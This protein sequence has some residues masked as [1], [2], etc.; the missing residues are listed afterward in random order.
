MVPKARI[1]YVPS[2]SVMFSQFFRGTYHGID[3][4]RQKLHTSN[5]VQRPADLSP[6]DVYA[7]LLLAIA[8]R[9]LGWRGRDSTNSSYAFK[10]RDST[11]LRLTYKSEVV[12][13]T[14]AN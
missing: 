7:G 1:T 6:N 8:D 13:I 14:L 9:G 5:R 11:S 12:N 2:C 10:F 4:T 3:A